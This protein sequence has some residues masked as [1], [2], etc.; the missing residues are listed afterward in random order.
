M[1]IIRKQEAKMKFNA[2]IVRKYLNGK[3]SLDD[4]FA[5]DEYF[6]ND[7]FSDNLNDVLEEHWEKLEV[8]HQEKSKKLDPV[9]DKINHQILLAFHRKEGKFKLLWQ[10]YS[11]VA[12]ILLLPVLIF[13]V[14]FYLRSADQTTMGPW[15]EVHSPYGARTQFSLP[16]G[17]TGW[18]NSGSVIKYPAQFGADRTVALNGEAY[19]DV[20][21]NPE[22]PFIVDANQ[23]KIKVLGTSFNVVSYERDSISEVVVASGKVEVAAV[24]KKGKPVILNPSG[25]LVLDRM[26]NRF[27]QTTVEVQN[28]TS[29][30]NG[31]LMFLNDNLDEVVR[32]ISRYYH[33]DFKI[34]EGVDRQQLFRGIMEKESLDEVLRYMKLTMNI[35]FQIKERK[36]D[37]EGRITKKEIIITNLAKK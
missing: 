26:E 12:A 1:D 31:Q 34:R 21:K 18:L 6:G 20:V 29:W 2:N 3:F 32:K 30:K 22:A 28:Y 37:E 8:A 4:K 27:V 10:V 25:R 11:K 16:D 7:R 13:S 33:V 35:D 17:S 24:G 14:Y 9:L 23:I 36:P 5:V 19:F 15:V